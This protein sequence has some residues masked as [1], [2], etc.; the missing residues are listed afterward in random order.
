MK[1]M[2]E[3]YKEYEHDDPGNKYALK[4]VLRFVPERDCRI[5]DVGCG[6]AL[7]SMH[8]RRNGNYLVGIDI[9]TSQ[10]NKAR[11]VLDEVVI[12]NLN[13]SMP[14][15]DEEFDMVYSAN[16][17]EHIFDFRYV[18]REM[19]RVLK[20]GGVCIVEVPNVAYWPNRLLMLLGREL[21]WIGVGKHIRAF[22][23]FNLKRS[24]SETGY[25]DVK[26]VG[27]IL[28]LPK[29]SLRVHFPYLNR[30]F[31]GLCFSLIGLGRKI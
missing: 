23:K 30:L 10:T 9:S 24:L 22:N 21:I 5:L 3:F 1:S 14:F 19:W 26:I 25:K 8:F 28:P 13:H 29:T 17:L 16:V 7:K 6:S 20:R 2:D 18:L 31:P 11:K 12:H 27:S 15:K 4:E